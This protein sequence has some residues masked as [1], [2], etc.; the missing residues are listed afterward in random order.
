MIVITIDTDGAAFDDGL[1]GSVEVARILR[2]LSTDVLECE[3]A[4]Q[5]TLI[6]INGNTCGNVTVVED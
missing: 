6:D 4:E 3:S 1:D 2:R 5:Q